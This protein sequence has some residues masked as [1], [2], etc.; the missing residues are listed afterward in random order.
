[1]LQTLQILHILLV[2]GLIKNWLIESWLLEHANEA[3]NALHP[4]YAFLQGPLLLHPSQP[5]VEKN[6]SPYFYGI[7]ILHTLETLDAVVDLQTLQS[8]LLLG[9][10]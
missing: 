4:L 5:C 6:L 9:H 7:Q 3:L 10:L 2:I 8:Y 1:M